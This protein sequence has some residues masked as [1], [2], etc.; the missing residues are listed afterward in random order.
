MQ[1]WST[2]I[3][4]QS[5]MHR[6]NQGSTVAARVKGGTRAAPEI[7]LMIPQAAGA[8]FLADPSESPRRVTQ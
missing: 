6:G 2:R 5:C 8:E 4:R 1:L 7:V 3:L